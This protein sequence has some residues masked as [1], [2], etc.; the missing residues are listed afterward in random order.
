MSVLTPTLP[1]ALPPEPVVRLSVGQYHTMIRTGVI[2][3]D[4]PLE[5]LEGWLVT[6]MPK[7]PPHRVATRSTRKALE[8]ILSPG[9]EVATQEPITTDDSEP[10]PDIC[11]VRAAALDNRERHPKPD[12]I[13]AVIEVAEA[14]LARDRGLKKRAYARAKIPVYWIINLVDQ[15][16]EVYTD[17]TGPADDPDY[18]LMRAF[19]RG[20]SIP[21]VV[22]GTEIGQ[23]DVNQLLG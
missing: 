16:I 1:P 9:W 11:V 21:V 23:L 20:A 6:K 17:P 14:T 12:E 7:N 22:D 3:A 4:D 2:N 18:G 15:H 10:E 8:R 19:K 13:A 5:L